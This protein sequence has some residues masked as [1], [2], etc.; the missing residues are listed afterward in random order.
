MRATHGLGIVC[1]SCCCC[2]C[3]CCCCQARALGKPSIVQETSPY[4][5]QIEQVMVIESYPVR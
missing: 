2:C 3:G 1:L 5:S 4:A